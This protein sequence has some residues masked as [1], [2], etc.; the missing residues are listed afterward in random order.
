MNNGH[1]SF[2][3]LLLAIKLCV[4]F[5]FIP[6]P[7]QCSRGHSVSSL[8]DLPDQKERF[9]RS[10]DNSV[11]LIRKE[12]DKTSLKSALKYADLRKF[13][14]Q[15][16]GYLFLATN[17]GF[18]L[19]GPILKQNGEPLFAVLVELAGLAS[20][21]YHFGQLKYG[22]DN[23]IVLRALLADYVIA[24]MTTLAFTITLFTSQLSVQSAESLACSLAGL[25]CLILSWVYE[26]GY[27]YLILH[28]S[29]H[30]FSAAA[31]YLVASAP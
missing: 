17:L 31:T 3:R 14:N 7:H 1:F 21:Y 2:I 18:F 22:P 6:S 26:F 11:R 25:V 29:W 19:V 30:V 8:F 9:V 23:P 24:A 13:D 10:I 28:G 12:L 15:P 4:V 5:S 27:P 20:T 16:P